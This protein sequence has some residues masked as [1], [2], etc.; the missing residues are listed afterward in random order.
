MKL[1]LG[2]FGNLVWRWF[3]ESREAVRGLIKDSLDSA[4]YDDEFP[5]APEQFQYLMLGVVPL[6]YDRL[7]KLDQEPDL[8]RRFCAFCREALDRMGPAELSDF[9]D[10]VLDSV[11]DPADVRVLRAADPGLVAVVRQRF[12]HRWPD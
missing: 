9:D 6:F 2:F 4:V 11:D 1:D 5:E 7:G 3:P 8:V 10:Y 12:P